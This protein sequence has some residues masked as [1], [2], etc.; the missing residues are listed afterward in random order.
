M[1]ATSGWRSSGVGGGNG[2]GGA[3]DVEVSGLAGFGV[4]PGSE[5]RFRTARRS[6]PR[7]TDV[8]VPPAR[9]STRR[10]SATAT[11]HS[12]AAASRNHGARGT[13]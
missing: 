13:R 6:S 1:S 7:E 12:N 9:L 10:L 11:G 3:I 2:G 5:G 4:R 8:V